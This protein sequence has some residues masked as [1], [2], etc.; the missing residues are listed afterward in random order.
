MVKYCLFKFKYSWA[1]KPTL[2]H[3]H[4]QHINPSHQTL[5]V[6]GGGHKVHKVLSQLFQNTCSFICA[7]LEA[8]LSKAGLRK[9]VSACI[10]SRFKMCPERA[11][12]FVCLSPYI[13]ESS[14]LELRPITRLLYFY[15]NRSDMGKDQTL[16]IQ[17]REKILLWLRHKAVGY[18]HLNVML[19]R[20]L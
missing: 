7:F 3:L 5:Q 19:L 10:E 12:H 2:V 15:W 13:E 9:S 17:G 4:A 11:H 14:L 6:T 8:P 1:A 20:C 18:T 16:F